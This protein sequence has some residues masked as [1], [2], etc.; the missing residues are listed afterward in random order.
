MQKKAFTLI[1]ILV[2]ITIFS[3]FMVSM[4][5]IYASSAN[6][7][8]KI[9]I[10]RSMQENTKNI[11]EFI[12]EDIR[13]NWISGVSM[14]KATDSCDFNYNLWLYKVWDKLCIWGNSYYLAINEWW[15]Y[16]RVDS[17][18][19]DSKC[20]DLRNECILV[21]NDGSSI[22][23]LSNSRVKFKNLKF[24]VSDKYIPKVTIVYEMQPS[25]KQGI[26]LDTIKHSKLN[27][28]TTLTSRIIKTN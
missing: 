19:M 6:T 9:D 20:S 28:Q 23:R 10:N 2:A 25:I 16:N 22:T 3:I 1:E 12:A 13:K 17:S 21:K 4:I 5:M 24:F 26:K 7:D 11:L 15:V 18:E 27:I 8:R 14:Q